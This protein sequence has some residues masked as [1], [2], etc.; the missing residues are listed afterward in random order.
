[1]SY[2]E[3]ISTDIYV[4]ISSKT[5][6]PDD[7][8]NIFSNWIQSISNKETVMPFHIIPYLWEE[9]DWDKD[10]IIKVSNLII[11]LLELVNDICE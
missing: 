3:A 4:Q 10:K 7:Y 11:N 5:D 9:S 6:T 1:M 8:S 2:L